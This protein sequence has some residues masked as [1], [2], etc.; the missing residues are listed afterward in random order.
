MK[1]LTTLV[2]L[3][4]GLLTATAGADDKK[5]A[6][7]HGHMM[8]QSTKAEDLRVAMR[9]LWEDHIQYT[10]GFIIS[11]LADL[12]DQ[13]AVTKR[14]LQ[15]QTDIGNAIVPYYGADAGK[16]LTELLRDHILIAADV[17]KAA[18]SGDKE[19]LDKQQK[20]WSANGKDLAAFLSTANP[21]WSKKELEDMLQK[22]LD[23]TTNEVVG[24][25]KGQWPKDI[26]AYDAGHQ[27]MMMFSDALSGGIVKQ[28]PDKF[29]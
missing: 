6:P 20:R 8:A 4:L 2:A 12:P 13:D 22:H 24:R 27:H 11:T 7:A 1:K 14:L 17:V 26:A 3:A 19:M 10:R 25:L 5:P 16:K 28:F 18:K 9:V 21:N 23:L 15:N 29:R